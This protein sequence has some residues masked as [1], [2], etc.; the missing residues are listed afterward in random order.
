[1]SSSKSF[2]VLGPVDH[3]IVEFPAGAVDAS[4]FAGLIDLVDRGLIYVL[5]LEFVSRPLQGDPYVL[6][7]AALP[8]SP[9]LSLLAGAS[10]GLLDADDLRAV[11][12][13]LAPGAVAAVVIFENRW[14]VPMLSTL[15]ASGGRIVSEN[16]VPVEDLLHA[17]DRVEATAPPAPQ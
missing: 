13:T 12:E 11:A 2:D 17:L 15:H 9:A 7:A 5:D 1:M 16:R 10:S 6:D 3:L 14:I 8:G 4:S